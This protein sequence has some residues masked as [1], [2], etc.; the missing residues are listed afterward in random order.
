MFTCLLTQWNKISC[1]EDFYFFFHFLAK[2]IM[3]NVGFIVIWCY[4][5]RKRN[6]KILLS[7]VLYYCYETLRGYLM[8]EYTFY[9]ICI[10][11]LRLWFLNFL[12]SNYMSNI[13]LLL[14]FYVSISCLL[15]VR[16][17]SFVKWQNIS[18]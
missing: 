6:M 5:N 17:N 9:A 15:N 13:A 18:F 8:E 4:T 14:I 10:L 7:Y 1:L 11:F 3:K 2:H 12:K 16:S